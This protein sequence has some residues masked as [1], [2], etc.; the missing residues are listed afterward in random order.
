MSTGANTYVQKDKK[1]IKK[2]AV[3]WLGIFV[4]VEVQEKRFLLPCLQE[5]GMN[6][7]ETSV[8]GK[9]AMLWPSCH[10][11]VKYGVSESTARKSE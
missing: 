10:C 6:L 9:C 5:A 2:L 1:R 11:R 8:T 4:S 7:I 3:Y